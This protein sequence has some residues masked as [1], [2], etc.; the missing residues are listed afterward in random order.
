MKISRWSIG[1]ILE[2]FFYA[3][4]FFCIGFYVGNGINFSHSPKGEEAFN[5]GVMKETYN[6]NLLD[7]SEC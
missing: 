1:L 4:S 6:P 3:I 5:L 7:F 2:A